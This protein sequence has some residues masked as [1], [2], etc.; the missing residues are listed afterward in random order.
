M[1]RWLSIALA[2]LVLPAGGGEDSVL[3]RWC[4]TNG[5]GGWLDMHRT[6]IGYGESTFCD[7]TEPVLPTRLYQATIRCANY[8]SAEHRAQGG[9]AFPNTF[10]ITARLA[11][12]G[13]LYVSYVGEDGVL[14]T[15]WT[16]EIYKLCNW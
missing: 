6:E 1:R 16:S 14:D 11:D 12:D 4:H 15:P 7:L 9:G 10:E 3:G 5:D 8:L 2:L 13:L